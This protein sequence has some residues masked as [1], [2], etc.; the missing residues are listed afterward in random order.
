MEIASIK[1]W[2]IY[3]LVYVRHFA[4]CRQCHPQCGS[5]PRGLLGR[6]KQATAGSERMLFGVLLFIVPTY[7]SFFI[8]L[9]LDYFVLSFKQR[10][11][12]GQ[13]QSIGGA[14]ETRINLLK[15]LFLWHCQQPAVCKSLSSLSISHNIHILPSPSSLHSLPS[16]QSGLFAVR[17]YSS[18]YLFLW[19]GLCDKSILFL[20]NWVYSRVV[21]STSMRSN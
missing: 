21:P 18:Q 3:H 14:N 19:K 20:S 11:D 2:H 13:T 5:F 4:G 1:A 12:I 7:Y 17:S 15:L 6:L 10:E 9:F 16:S 8:F